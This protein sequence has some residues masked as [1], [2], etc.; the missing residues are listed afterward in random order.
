MGM[1]AKAR[2]T[3]ASKPGPFLAT[4]DNPEEFMATAFAIAHAARSAD[5]D[6]NMTEAEHSAVIHGIA[7]LALQ[8]AHAVYGDCYGAKGNG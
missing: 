1:E 8:L 3:I 2:V 6:R 4:V 7:A 5:N